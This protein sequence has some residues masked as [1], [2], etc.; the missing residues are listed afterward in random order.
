Q[1]HRDERNGAFRGEVLSVQV[2]DASGA[3]VGSHEA[4]GELGDGQRHRATIRQLAGEG[5]LAAVGLNPNSEVRRPKET[6]SPKPEATI[7]AAG[8]KVIGAIPV[9]PSA[10]GLRPS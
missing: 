6:R 10:F 9:R 4:V 5:K 3:G 2:V 7:L 8:E 1:I